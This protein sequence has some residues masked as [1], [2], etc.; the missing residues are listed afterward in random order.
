MEIIFSLLVTLIIQIPIVFDIIALKILLKK[1]QFTTKQIIISA[2]VT[3]LAWMSVGS[4]L[5]FSMEFSYFVLPKGITPK[6]MSM[7]KL[8]ILIPFLNLIPAVI[9]AFIF[10]K[11]SSQTGKYTLKQLLPRTLVARVI[12]AILWLGGFSILAWM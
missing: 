9:E 2:L 3:L 8:L 12:A 11:L 1:Y 7:V 4:I 6:D 10:R 5:S